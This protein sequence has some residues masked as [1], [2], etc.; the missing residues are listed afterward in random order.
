MLSSKPLRSLRHFS[1][2]TS[3]V[4]EFHCIHPAKKM[5]IPDT[6]AAK[7]LGPHIVQAKEEDLNPYLQSIT[8]QTSQLA[9][10]RINCFTSIAVI[11]VHAFKRSPLDTWALL[12]INIPSPMAEF[13]CMHPAKKMVIPDTTAAKFLGPH[14]VQAK[15]EDLNPYLQS[16]THQTS[17]LAHQRINCFTSIAVIFVHAFK[18]SH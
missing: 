7:F 18:Q 14:K 15:E 17:Q 2:S 4:A 10:Q 8:H 3:P 13:H 5:V 9:H 11:F 16:I 12:P 1:L 6:T